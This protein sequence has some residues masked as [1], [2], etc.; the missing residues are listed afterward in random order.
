MRYTSVI[1]SIALLLAFTMTAGAQVADTTVVNNNATTPNPHTTVKRERVV[2]LVTTKIKLL[3]RTYGDSIVLRW[4]AEDYVSYK[5]LAQYGV[6]V[7]RVPH[8]ARGGLTIDTLAYAL[9][10]L[11]LDEFRA[12]YP[13]TDS[14]ALVPQGVLYGEA[15]NRHKYNESV[16]GRTTEYNADQNLSYGFAML[17]AEWRKDLA[18]DMALRLTD[19][20]VE[21]GMTYDYYI[22]PTVWENGGR[23]IFEPGVAEG[24]KNEPY[25]PKAFDPV[26]V[27]SLSN[28]YTLTLGWWDHEHSSYEVERR[29]VSTLKGEPRNGQWQRITTKPYVPMV[30]QPEGEDYCLIADSVPELGIYEYRILGYDAFA[31]LSAPTQ[32]HRVVVRDVEAPSAPV[33]KQIVL[34]RP[35][36]DDP[37]AKVIA[38]V[39][40]EKAVLED[41]LVGYCV[42]YQSTRSTGGQWTLLNDDMIAPQDTLFTV[43]MTGRSTGFIYISAF[44]DSGNESRSFVQQIALRD[45][46]A[47]DVPD[48]LTA[49]VQ[50]PEID[51]LQ[52]MSTKHAYVILRWKPCPDDDIDYY[53]IAFANDTTHTF[54]VRNEGGIRET[55]FVDS[56]ALDA[57]Q[58]YVYYQVRAVDYSTNV[59]PWSPW[60]E[61]ARPHVTPPTEPHIDNSSHSDE[62][63]MHMEWIVGTDADMTYHEAF[64]RVG[65][66]G[67]WQLIGRYDQDSLRQVG[68][69]IV[70]D[71]NPPFDREQRYYYYVVSHNQSPFTTN[72]LAIS[73]LHRGPKVWPVDLKLFG[74]YDE[75]TGVTR[76][77]WER[78]QLPKELD[79]IDY[80]YCIYR[81]GP[82]QADFEFVVS[83]PKTDAEYTDRLL[84][85]G[86][87]AE[88]YLQLQWRDGRQSN[89][90]NIVKVGA[91]QLTIDN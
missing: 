15:E 78:G 88:Y 3:T 57:N 12:K 60:I 1:I 36:D 5:Y 41:D 14:A 91:S 86:E 30:E 50:L 74:N 69:R 49:T 51:T 11:T 83:V 68:Y 22:Q 38:H 39:I 64:R 80:Y 67:E 32:G 19:R 81:K 48:S 34:E 43:D 82:G 84:R 52:A 73:W 29:M 37:M 61:V 40:W 18:E 77:V 9:K 21:P 2:P 33:L 76:L 85:K 44:D 20:N 53:D 72:S 31:D 45:W 55:A 56:L 58:Q 42:N 35:D 25:V 26:M 17:V 66:E 46:K 90:S 70:I 23:L 75:K 7:L 87:Q 79:S 59:G 8:D 28:P 65:D 47:P 63:G 89:I 24:V 27:D 10:P 54:V 4:A 6:N 71:D 16:M 62:K 13:P